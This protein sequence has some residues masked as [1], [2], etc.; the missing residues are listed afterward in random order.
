MRNAISGGGMANQRAR[1][2][3]NNATDAERILWAKLRALKHNGLHFRRQAPMGRYIVDFV[4]HSAKLIIEVDGSQ[5]G[6]E[7]AR[8]YDSVRT[9][10]LELEG[11][12]VLRYWNADAMRN[13]HGIADAIIQIANSPPSRPIG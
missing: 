10:F 8:R 6:E 7:A 3:R 11:Y 1:E 5:H 13:S 9:A 2:L 12:R 4:C